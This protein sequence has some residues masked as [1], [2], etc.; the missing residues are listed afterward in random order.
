[1]FTFFSVYKMEIEMRSVI[2]CYCR[3]GKGGKKIHHKLSDV[4]DKGSCSLG[5]VIDWVR[6]FK[7]QR[8][9]FHDEVRPGRALIDVSAQIARPL[10]D[11]PFSSTR[12]LAGYLAVTKDVVNRNLQ[13]ILRF[14]KFNLKWVP[15]VLSAEHKAARAQVLRELYN[16]LIFKRQKNF[17]TIITGDESWYRGKKSHPDGG[18]TE[19]VEQ[20]DMASPLKT[21]LGRPQETACDSLTY[22]DYYSEYSIDNNRRNGDGDACRPTRFSHKHAKP[23]ACMVHAVAPWDRALFVLRLLLQQVPA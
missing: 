13:E 8:I 22:A 9:D 7:P 1:M 17:A 18:G 2:F 16:N 14:H 10:N 23:C 3:Q 6:K 5:A 15:N 12:H 4:Y 21:Y 11:E 19:L 20:G